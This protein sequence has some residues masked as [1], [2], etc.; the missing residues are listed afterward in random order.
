[1][2]LPENFNDFENLQST[3]ILVFRDDVRDEFSD[4]G[5]DN[6]EPDINVPRG[7][8]R[9]ACTPK[10]NDTA[11]MLNMRSNLFYFGLRKAQDLQAPIMGMPLWDVMASRKFSPQIQLYFSQDRGEMV[12]TQEAPVAGQ[13]TFR[14]INQSSTTLSKT[15]LTTYANRIKTQFNSASEGIWYRG[16]NMATYTDIENGYALKILT[17]TKDHAKDL[18]EKCL[19]IQTITYNSDLLNYTTADNAA[20]RYP[21]A[22]P[23]KTILGVSRKQPVRRRICQVRFRYATAWIHGLNNKI[24]LYDKSGRYIAP[25]AN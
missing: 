5:D 6:W 15:E 24:A 23:N 13:I 14:L 2:P 22:P 21:A 10:D 11:E 7:R 8:L 18:I 9:V 3:F 12:A 19:A 4:L 25:L 16:R 20:G 1:M 17:D